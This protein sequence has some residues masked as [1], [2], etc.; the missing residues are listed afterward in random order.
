MANVAFG[1]AGVLSA[2]HRV[3]TDADLGPR[4]DLTVSVA[5]AGQAAVRVTTAAVRVLPAQ[6]TGDVATTRW[7]TDVDACR[8]WCAQPAAA[9]ATSVAQHAVYLG[10]IGRTF[11]RLGAHADGVTV[12]DR[13]HAGAAIV[14]A[15]AR[16]AG[17]YAK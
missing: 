8:T 1:I 14:V 15:S 11:G 4:F 12:R 6:I 13:A 3:G 7:L 2:V 17:L 5:S 16:V 10:A 9:I